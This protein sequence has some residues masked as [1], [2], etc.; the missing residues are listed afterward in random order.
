MPYIKQRRRERFEI[1]IQ[2]L[3]DDLLMLPEETAGNLNYVI[4]SLLYRIW[5][6]HAKYE[7]ANRLVGVLECAKLEFYRRVIS[8][9]EDQKTESNGDVFTSPKGEQS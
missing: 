5:Q 1:P 7:M 4:S 3:A 2:K 9:Y 6:R 8:K